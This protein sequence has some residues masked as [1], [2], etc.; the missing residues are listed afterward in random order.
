M[1][2]NNQAIECIMMSGRDII[3]RII[4]QPRALNYALGRAVEE[5]Q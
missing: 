5:W 4:P 3:Y 1:Q 2:A